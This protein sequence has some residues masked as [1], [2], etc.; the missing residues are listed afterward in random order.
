VPHDGNTPGEMECHGHFVISGYFEDEAADSNAFTEDGWFK[1]GDVISIDQFGRFKVVD[2]LKDMVKSG[3]EWIS[4]QTL[5]SLASTHPAV[6]EAAVIGLPH[7]RWNERPLLILRL[8][9]GESITLDEIKEHILLSAPKWWLPDAIKVVD[10]IPHASTGK[11]DKRALRIA[12]QGYEYDK[13]G[14]L[15][16][17]NADDL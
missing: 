8:Q 6:A 9:S 10:S 1:T 7:P 13:K 11:I 2:R 14:N 4:S 17:I 16:R 12:Y 5:E 15:S 3:G